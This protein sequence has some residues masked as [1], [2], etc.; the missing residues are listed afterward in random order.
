MALAIHS[1]FSFLFSFPGLAVW[2]FFFFLISWVGYAF[3]FFFFFFT[4]SVW[5]FFFF[6]LDLVNLGTEKENEKDAPVIGMGPTN[7]VKNIE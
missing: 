4:S 5:F 1:F 3:L 6:S 7:S 2:F